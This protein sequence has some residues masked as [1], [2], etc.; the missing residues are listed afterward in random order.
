MIE[1][2]APG[3][4]VLVD[5]PGAPQTV[6][7]V[8]R[9]V[10]AAASPTREARAC[11]DTVFG[12]SFTSRLNANLREDKGYTYG[13]GSRIQR[14]GEQWLMLAY[15]SVRTDV[16]GA[17]L[18]EF[19]REFARMRADGIDEGELSKAVETL[20][21]RVV[22]QAETTG[23]QAG[24]L[25]ALVQNELPLDDAHRTLE[26]LASVSLADVNALAKSELYDWDQLLIVLVG[27]AEAVVPQLEA[28]GFGAP[29]RVDADGKEL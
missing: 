22:G 6:V 21:G 3:R 1:E 15:S 5:R 11:V 24:S 12:G 13:A 20:R 2:P 14:F 16:T 8:L 17:S 28:A 26:A 9:P 7:R 4:I 27:D 10:L 29:V 25:A 18:E 23:G 19:Q